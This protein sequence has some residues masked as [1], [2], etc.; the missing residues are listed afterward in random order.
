[1]RII[2]AKYRIQ[3]IKLVLYHSFAGLLIGYFI[4]H[5]ISMVIY[6]FELNNSEFSWL[7]IGY[8]LLK[9]SVIHLAFI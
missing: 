5:P 2:T 4:L 7:K 8:V 6:W 9:A 3:A 1:M